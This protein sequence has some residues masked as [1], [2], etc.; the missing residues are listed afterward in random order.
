VLIG[1]DTLRPCPEIAIP[2]LLCIRRDPRH[3]LRAAPDE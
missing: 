3:S 2:E 1:G